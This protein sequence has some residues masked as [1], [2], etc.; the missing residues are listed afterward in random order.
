M[1]SQN[2]KPARFDELEVNS[3]H[4]ETPNFRVYFKLHY[5]EKSYENLKE[6][7]EERGREITVTK[8]KLCGDIFAN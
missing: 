2:A 1:Y 7:N 6:A 3:K 4:S 5:L 8:F